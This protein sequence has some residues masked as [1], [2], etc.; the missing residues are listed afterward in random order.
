MRGVP[1]L[2]LAGRGRVRHAGKGRGRQGLVARG[3]ANEL[4]LVHV[5]LPGG[6]QRPHRAA[7]AARGAAPAPAPALPLL[8]LL[9]LLLA[10]QLLMLAAASPAP[11]LLLHRAL[12]P[13]LCPRVRLLPRGPSGRLGMLRCS[14]AWG[15]AWLQAI[16]AADAAAAVGQGRQ[17]LRGVSLGGRL[18]GG[19]RAGLVVRAGYL[20]LGTRE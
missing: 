10:R 16:A 14:C 1:L 11:L 12:L 18:Q 2:L 6:W 17:I 8:L 13:R 7:A 15:R 20:R 3:Q 5:L 9:L 19:K 4:Q